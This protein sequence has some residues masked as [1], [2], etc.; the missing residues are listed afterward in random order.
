MFTARQIQNFWRHVRRG[1]ANEC[2]PWTA[3][4]RSAKCPYGKLG[5]KHPT[6]GRIQLAHRMS[7]MIAHGTIT[8]E[9]QVLHSCDNPRCVNPAHLF[10]G[11][12]AVNMADRLQKGRCAD[13]KGTKNGRVKLTPD[14]VLAIRR[15]RD[16]WKN[17][18]ALAVAYGVCAQT[19]RDILRRKLWKHL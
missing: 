8:S 11:T 6:V 15:S 9:Q 17:C 1:A 10:L 12:H 14:D 3:S 7:Y 18:T 4:V 5:I 19:I 13:T 16:T 2:W